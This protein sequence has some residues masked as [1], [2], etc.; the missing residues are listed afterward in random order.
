MS[1]A[2][3]HNQTKLT[4]SPRS[5]INNVIS[6]RRGIS[7]FTVVIHSGASDESFWTENHEQV[8][9]A[10][11]RQFPRTV[12]VSDLS[13][14]HWASWKSKNIEMKHKLELHSYHHIR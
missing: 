6:S 8:S 10:I 14:H 4:S 11:C 2:R 3:V 1:A 5:K 12:G 9:R 7:T 13:R